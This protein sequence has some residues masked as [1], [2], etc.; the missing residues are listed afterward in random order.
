[1]LVR[2]RD[3]LTFPAPSLCWTTTGQ[4]VEST[5]STRAT[6][7]TGGYPAEKGEEGEGDRGQEGEERGKEAERD[8]AALLCEGDAR[9]DDGQAQ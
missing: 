7:P 4:Y 2:I 9:G 1:M 3:T 6:R 8:V 5:C